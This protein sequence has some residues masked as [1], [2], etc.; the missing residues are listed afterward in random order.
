MTVRASCSHAAEKHLASL[1]GSW[2]SVP[3]LRQERGRERAQ[4]EELLYKKQDLIKCHVLYQ[5]Q[6]AT[7]LQS[8]VTQR[9]VPAG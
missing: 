8:S 2:T 4:E 7:D 1:S 6:S 5:G 3:G 9:P